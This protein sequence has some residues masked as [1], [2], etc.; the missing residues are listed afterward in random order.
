ME[1]ASALTSFSA[2]M[3]LGKSAIS[4]RDDVKIKAALN[5]AEKKYSEAI[6]AVLSL[7]ERLLQA[8]EQIAALQKSIVQA[9]N[10]L[11]DAEI[12]A[13]ER[14]GYELVNLCTGGDHF[15]AYKRQ[16]ADGAQSNQVHYLCQPCY[17]KEVKSVLQVF[18]TDYGTT[19]ACTSCKASI[20]I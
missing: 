4:A 6:D 20:V 14:S 13:K 5:G 11:R 15:H 18:R 7:Q 17:D 2:L 12:K 3:E 19:Y 8:Q 10:A 16:P 9:N 1:L